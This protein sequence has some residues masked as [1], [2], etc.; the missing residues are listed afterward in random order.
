MNIITVAIY[1]IFSN[2]F[3]QIIMSEKIRNQCHIYVYNTH[4]HTHIYVYT[5]SPII[6]KSIEGLFDTRFDLSC[7]SQCGVRVLEI[8]MFYDR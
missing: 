8:V 4:T 2:I 1:G 3:V 7:G 6:N 5:L